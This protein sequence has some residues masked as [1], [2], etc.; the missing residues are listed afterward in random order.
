MT[1][2]E[3]N[4][5]ILR[6]AF[7]MRDFNITGLCVPD[8]HYMA[9]TSEKIE[10]IIQMVDKGLYFTI[11]RARQFGKTTTLNF[12]YEKLS[13]KYLV[14]DTSFEG[15][16][17]IPFQSEPGFCEMFAENCAKGLR[18]TDA[19]DELR[20]F[21]EMNIPENIKT[22]DKK[23]TEFCEMS[24]KP[25]VLL[26]DEV[27]KTSD[28]QN[29]LNFLGML[30]NKYLLRN[31][32]KD[33]TFQSIILAGVYDI[34]NL[35]LKMADKETISASGGR[36]YNS[37]WN[38][39]ADFDIDMSLSSNEISAMLVDYEKDF[40][41]GMDIKKI[42]KEIRGYT[43]GYPFLVSK[44][45]KIIDEKLDRKWTVGG[46]TDAVKILL[47]DGNTLFDDM[48]KNIENNQKLYDLIFDVMIGG[49]EIPFSLEHPETEL[50]SMYGI[51]MN[52][53]GKVAIANELFELRISNYLAAKIASVS[54]VT[55]YVLKEDVV[56]NGQF[57]M[58][59]CLEKFGRHFYGLYNENDEKFL[60]KYCRMLFITYLKPLINGQGF[61][62]IE[63][64]TRNI[65]RMDLILDYGKEQFV[66][67]MK[68]WRSGKRHK[69]AYAKLWD[70]LDGKG[71]N[72]G[73]LLTF[74]FRKE[75]KEVK[76][77]WVEFE[78]KR[79]FDIVI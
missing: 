21:W 48:F 4:Q 5:E 52:K 3:N 49:K 54:S 31:R 13:G 20:S 32:G 58:P 27:D 6:E 71:L 24:E 62:H 26:I 2:V 10:K 74:D 63:A 66:I 41:T 44:I 45:C 8:K 34:K 75:G 64:Q 77:E 65:R 1:N 18:Y 23:I 72:T 7:L 55:N 19:R 70:Y 29:F 46:V 35:K 59:L 14:I 69:D 38:I 67:E 61:Y 39:A 17:S 68:L 50:G 43:N 76:S 73:Y 11:N 47:N 30:R 40:H 36:A 9:D 42:S 12:L 15:V 22:L 56:K 28:N 78:G 57:D 79:I 33:F 37:P 60:E 53:D 16:G 51:F 25:V